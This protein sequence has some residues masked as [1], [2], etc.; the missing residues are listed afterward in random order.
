[1]TYPIRPASSL[2]I[3]GA[4]RHA[5][6]SLV[7]TLAAAGCGA[8]SGSD[9]EIASAASGDAVTGALTMTCSK[10]TVSRG[11][12]GAGQTAAALAT[13]DLTGQQDV[14]SKY[15]E[16]APGTS[17]TCEYALPSGTSAAQLASLA[18]GVN[19]RG[20]ARTDMRWTFEAWDAAAR[21]WVPVGDNAFARDWSWTSAS[22]TL[23]GP[24]GRFVAGG[25]LKIRYATSS[26]ADSSMLD[27]LV[28]TGTTSG[29]STGTGGSGAGGSTGTGGSGAGGSTGTGG[30]G[31]GGSTGTGGSGAGGSGA[32]GSGGSTGTGGSGAGGSTGTGGSGTGGSGAGGSTG[33][34]G[35]TGGI[36]V[37]APGTTWQWQLTGTIDTSL[38]V[39]MY[40]IDL[41]DA[42][43][44]KIDTLRAAGKKVICYFSAGSSED[45]RDDASSFPAA[46][47][48]NP[49]D[50]WPGERW[51][52]TRNAGVRNVMKARLDLA[53]QKRCDGVE[54]DNVD[55]YTNSP[56]FP[57][58]AATQLDYNRFLAAEAHA[59]GLSIGLKNDLDQVKDLVGS[60]DWALN[61]ECH[62]YGECEMLTPFIRAG[63]AVFHAEYVDASK[64]NAVCSATKPLGLSTLIKKLDLDAWRVACP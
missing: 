39:A 47:L 52:D 48:G 59:R 29:G 35:S 1:M 54:P 42:P 9:A 62:E 23:P 20:P 57:L 28:L 58:T 27:K 61:E 41:F 6:V 12:I 15:V 5:L 25:T 2:A 21:A 45:W 34:G 32:G 8:D 50:G 22:L 14:W 49:L 51:L 19:Y 36:W 24:L 38:D 56:G 46:G 11:S 13:A 26:S 37:P 55:G 44:A 10:L 17:A 60:F 63:K 7:A 3:C 4:L 40:D 43:Q 33:T 30:S 18:L 31:A 53:V 64:A 16:F